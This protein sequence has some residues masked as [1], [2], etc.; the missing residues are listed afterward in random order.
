MKGFG[1]KEIALAATLATLYAIL[2]LAFSSISFL[3]FQI[4][5][6]NALMG[7]VPILGPPA[8]IGLS[9]GVLIANVFSPLGPIDL[10]SSAFSLISLYIVWKLR[11]V[12]VFMGLSIYSVILGAWVSFM[13]SY[14]FRTPYLPTFAYVTVG[15]FIATTI[16]GYLL[17]R[18]MDK[19]IPKGWRV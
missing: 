11:K 3:I 17:Y 6:A 14:I 4:R 19:L 18:V 2:V 16:L 10:A 5:V 13:I 12:S 9:L 8:I 7:L 15:I 1:T